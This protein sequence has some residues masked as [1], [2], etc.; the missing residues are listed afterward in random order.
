MGLLGQAPLVLSCVGACRLRRCT[1]VL[2]SW[3]RGPTSFPS[4]SSC[5]NFSSFSP[6]PLCAAD[7]MAFH[8]QE[9]RWHG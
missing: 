9:G 4:F 5:P 7:F 1:R 6:N 2:R 3:S 8:L